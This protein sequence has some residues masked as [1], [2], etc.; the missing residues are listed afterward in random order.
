MFGYNVRAAESH[1]QLGFRFN[2]CRRKTG[3][4]CIQLFLCVEI[5]NCAIYSFDI[6]APVANLQSRSTNLKVLYVSRLVLVVKCISTH[7]STGNLL[8]TVSHKSY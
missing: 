5:Y 1:E 2:K 4:E 3:I 6:L 7:P 8:R